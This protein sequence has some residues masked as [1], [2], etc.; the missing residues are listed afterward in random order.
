MLI[1]NSAGEYVNDMMTDERTLVLRTS[2]GLAI[3]TGCAHRGSVNITRD[4]Q[5]KF[6]GENIAMV[7]GGFHLGK[8]DNDSIQKR[9]D[10]FKT[11]NIGGIGLCHCTGARACKMFKTQLGDKCFIAPA[12]SEILL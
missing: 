7:L 3:I 6:P 10:A 8:T 11:M 12:G 4:V 1:K 5:N 9:I 2:Q